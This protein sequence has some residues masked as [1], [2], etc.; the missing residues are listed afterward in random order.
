MGV[1]AYLPRTILTNA[2]LAKR[3][4]TS[5]EWIRERTGIQERHIVAK[6]EK[7]SD[8]AL[9][10]ARAALHHAHLAE[11]VNAGSG[12]T[13]QALGQLGAAGLGDSSALAMVNRFVDQQAYTMAATDLFHLSA[14]LFIALIVTVWLTKPRRSGAPADAG[15]AH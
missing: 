10:A 11:A 1:G 15:G 13:T 12:A 9:H 3:V 5:D 2:E 4:D 6:G 8:L 14:L 7:T